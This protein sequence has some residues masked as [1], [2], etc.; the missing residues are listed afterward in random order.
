[1]SAASRRAR[2]AAV[3]GL[4]AGYVSRV[5][6]AGV[7]F[8]V[9]GVLLF[10]ILVAFAAVRYFFDG[11]FEM[12][13][14]HAVFS[15][16][17]YPVVAVIYLTVGWAATG[18]SVGK[19]LLGLRVVRDNGGTLGIVRAAARAVICVTFAFVSL[20]WVVFSR[21]NAAVHDLVLRTSVVHDW[22]P[23]REEPMLRVGIP[24]GEPA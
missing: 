18:R 13:H 1:M 4:R 22:T 7:D 10:A 6:A 17:A 3:R 9:V 11:T 24:G 16:V 12:P 15:A 20:F 19:E 14:F 21:R 5:L 23:V 8:V 2:A